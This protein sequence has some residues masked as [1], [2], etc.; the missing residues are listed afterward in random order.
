MADGALIYLSAK[1]QNKTKQNKTNWLKFWVNFLE[2]IIFG[3]AKNIRSW[4]MSGVSVL[5]GIGIQRSILVEKKI[6]SVTEEEKMKV[7]M[8][9]C[10]V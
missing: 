2:M 10:V 6:E 4:E 3:I 9:V 1:Q 8:C 5:Y 7:C